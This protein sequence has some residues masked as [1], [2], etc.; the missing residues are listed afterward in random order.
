MITYQREILSLYVSPEKEGFTN[1]VS[2]VTWCWSAKEDFDFTTLYV[3]TY[4]STTDP[5]NFI[6]Y[7]DLTD[8]IVFGWIDQ[9]EDI[10]ALKNRLDEDLRTAKNPPIVE[11][12]IPWHV[13]TKYTGNEEYLLVIDDEVDNPEK[14]WGLVRWNSVTANEKLK[15][16]GIT[17]YEFPIDADMYRKQ[18]LP[19]DDVLVVND[20][21]KLYRVEY[22]AAPTFDPIF[23]YDNGITW[24]TSSGKAICTRVVS[25]RTVDEVKV[26]LNN[27]LAT[28]SHEK[29][30]SGFDYVYDDQ[31]VR[32][33]LDSNTRI[34]LL[35]R[36]LLMSDSDMVD[37]KLSDE[38][39]TL[40]KQD[41][42][43]LLEANE[44]NISSVLS[45]EKNKHD[46]I[47]SCTTIEQLKSIE[48]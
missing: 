18:I 3:D 12:N 15:L 42:R 45:W 10:D 6:D 37:E 11:K 34:N 19:V 29:Q 4:F 22:S 14:V 41:V 46:Q 25:D 28:A 24:D 31:T 26:G 23:Q 30:I 16:C 40:S 20:R 38:W 33:V 35:Q 1:V 27:R 7:S 13:D 39:F 32:I 43:N 47:M 44:N 48:I 8:E 21:I 17:N 36:W 9:V 5:N 2:R